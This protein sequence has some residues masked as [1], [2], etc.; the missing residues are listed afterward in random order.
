MA[1]HAASACIRCMRFSKG[2]IEI[3]FAQD[4]PLLRQV[5]H[6]QFITHDQLFEFMDIGNY[7]R[8]RPTFNWRVRRL[9]EHD[10]PNRYYFPE[11]DRSCPYRIG[12]RTAGVAEFAPLF[13][14][15]PKKPVV[16]PSMCT[17]WIELNNIHLSLAPVRVCC[18]NGCLK[19]RLYLGTS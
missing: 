8:K 15:R 3:S 13:P 5:L 4:M 17:H 9:V 11:I 19:R 16:E 2:S 7:E 6:S 12:P 18:R 14:I 10:F 1:R